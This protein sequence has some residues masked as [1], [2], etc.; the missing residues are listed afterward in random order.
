MQVRCGM[1]GAERV[2]ARREPGSRVTRW[3]TVSLSA[4]Q[5][6]AQRRVTGRAGVPGVEPHIRLWQRP[7]L[8]ASTLATT[9]SPM[10]T[11][12]VPQGARSS[13]KAS[14]AWR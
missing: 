14:P 12:G 5:V 1:A 9:P 13:P 6:A 11:T 3:P 7:M 4:E 8:S 2:A 10:A